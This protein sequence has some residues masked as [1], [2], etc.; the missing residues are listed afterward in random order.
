MQQLDDGL[1]P[2]PSSPRERRQT[3]FILRV[4]LDLASIEQ[5]L[6]DSVVPSHGCP[7]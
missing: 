3:V 2:V 7:R 1:V 5:K 6:D 4:D